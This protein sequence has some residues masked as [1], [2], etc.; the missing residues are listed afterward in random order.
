MLVCEGVLPHTALIVSPAGMG[1]PVAM[2]VTV[3]VAVQT[4]NRLLVVTELLRV[5]VTDRVLG[6]GSAGQVPQDACRGGSNKVRYYGGPN[7]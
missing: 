3:T 6:E 4:L 1:L 7:G 5:T 2:L